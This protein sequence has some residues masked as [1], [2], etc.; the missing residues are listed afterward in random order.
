MNRHGSAA[1]MKRIAVINSGENSSSAIRLATKAS[2]Q[3]I[4]TRMA[5]RISA[6][7][8][9]V[10]GSALSCSPVLIRLALLAGSWFAQQIGAVH[11]CVVI[12]R[13]QREADVGQHPLHHPAEGG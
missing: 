9:V 1:M 4:A 5:M 3:M 11:R 6:G 13:D 2:P 12:G 10:L 7:F 8:I